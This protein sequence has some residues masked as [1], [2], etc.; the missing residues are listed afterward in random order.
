MPGAAQDVPGSGGV[1]AH[2]GHGGRGRADERDGELDK[3]QVDKGVAAAEAVLVVKRLRRALVQR[4]SRSGGV[5]AVSRRDRALYVDLA[6]AVVV[7]QVL[8][9]SA[10]ERADYRLCA[11]GQEAV[12]ALLRKPALVRS[13][14]LPLVFYGVQAG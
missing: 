4:E 14:A 13:R 1:V 11:L 12:D 2:K 9:L 3:L 7:R 6:R 8:A 10:A 5:L